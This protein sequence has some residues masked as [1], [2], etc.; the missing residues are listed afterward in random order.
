[1]KKE[2]KGGEKQE[3]GTRGWSE[4]EG[5][6]IVDDYFAMLEQDLFGKAHSTTEH[7]KARLPKL[8][9][10]S[11]GS[12]EFKRANISAVLPG[13][14]LP[15]IEGYKPRGTYQALLAREVEA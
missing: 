4:E 10:G 9:D 6:L 15:Y 3:P 11:E 5:R 12:V 14:G 8:D 1:M 7:R 2:E 13:L